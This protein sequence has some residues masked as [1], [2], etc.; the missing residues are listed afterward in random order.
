MFQ[1]VDKTNEFRQL[2]ESFGRAFSKAR[3][4]KGAQPFSLLAR[5]E[6]PLSAF[7]F[8]SFFF[9][10]TSRKEKA[11]KKFIHFDELFFL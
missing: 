9:A 1:V 11:A 4:V 10:P 8:V 6:I 5:G 2:D 7:L 3:A